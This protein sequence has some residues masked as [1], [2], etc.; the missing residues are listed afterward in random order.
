MRSLII[1]QDRPCLRLRVRG[2]KAGRGHVIEL[3]NL[4][5]EEGEAGALRV[6]EGSRTHLSLAALD[7]A[8][9]ALQAVRDD[10][11]ADEAEA[12]KPRLAKPTPP[13]SSSGRTLYRNR[14][15]DNRDHR[16]EF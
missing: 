10:L 4:T 13:P 6:V 15:G 16:G 9:I 7:E 12:R 11:I 2:V 14:P 5:T 8:I 1:P 3:A